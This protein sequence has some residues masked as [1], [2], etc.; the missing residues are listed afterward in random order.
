MSLNRAREWM[1]Q[2]LPRWAWPISPW[3]EKGRP[4]LPERHQ[5]ITEL[6]ELNLRIDRLRLRQLRGEGRLQ[7]WREQ[8]RG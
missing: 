5:T 4:D 7:E 3:G 1:V 8:H 2:H 6:T